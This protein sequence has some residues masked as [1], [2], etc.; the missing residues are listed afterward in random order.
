MASSPVITLLLLP[1]PVPRHTLIPPGS[2]KVTRQLSTLQRAAATAITGGLRTSPTD[3]LDACAFLLPSPLNIDK[4]CHRALTRMAMLPKE[5]PLHSVVNRKNT[6]EVKRH[7]TA[8]HNL[9][10]RYQ[11]SIDPRKIEK[12]PATSQDPILAAAIPFAI[13]IPEDRESSTREAKNAAEEVQ[14]FSDGSAIEGKVGAAAV[15]L[16]AGKPARTLHLHLGSEEKH[17]VHEAES[18]GIVLGLHL[19]STERKNGTTF[20]LGSDNQAAIKA[21]QSNLRSSGHH[22]A[23]EA[24]RIAHQI[25]H[26]KRKTKYALTI[27]WTAG[28]E[29]IEG[30]EAVDREA[31]K[32]AEGLTLDLTGNAPPP[33]PEK[34]PTHEPLSSKESSHRSSQIQVD[35]HLAQIE[36]RGE[37]ASDR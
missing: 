6:R 30:N 8:I 33:V 3:T 1:V 20:A 25:L 13:S 19:I 26:R 5:H 2:A 22:L 9:L 14:V 17:T 16:R 27:R 28:H 23:R 36:K 29:G 21:F 11:D 31:K 10:D 12:I 34:T 15:L 7:R 32:A 18:A 24:L 35:K 37:D 4:R